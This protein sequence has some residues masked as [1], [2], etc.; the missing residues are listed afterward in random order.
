[1][2]YDFSVPA[3]GGQSIEAVGIFLKYKSGLGK[4]RIKFNNGGALDLTPGQSVSG[5]NFT[6]FTVTD[7]SGAAN[8]GVI[9]AGAFAM[10]D[11]SIVGAVSIIDGGVASSLANICYM[12]GVKS[13]AVAGEMNFVMLDNPAGTG[14]NVIVESVTYSIEA[15]NAF[16]LATA[17]SA[18]DAFFP[19][20]NL[21]Y[22]KSKNSAYGSNSAA[23]IK[24]RHFATLPFPDKFLNVRA[25]IGKPYPSHGA[26]V[27]AVEGVALQRRDYQR[28]QAFAGGGAGYRSIHASDSGTRVGQRSGGARSGASDSGCRALSGKAVPHGRFVGCHACGLQ[29]GHRQRATQRP[30]QRAG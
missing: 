16:Q 10:Q 4:I 22:G 13:G 14:K 29:L 1:M 11:D 27:A 9:L 19:V 7:R 17:A 8:A 3:N 21:A 30:C 18:T 28:G 26:G 15:G 6:G 25:E 2:Q 12:G 24:G 5:L 23:A 20:T